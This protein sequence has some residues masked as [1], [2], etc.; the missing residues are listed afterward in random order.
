MFIIYVTLSYMFHCLDCDLHY[1][2]RLRSAYRMYALIPKENG[3]TGNEYI[4]FYCET[5]YIQL[6][7]LGTLK[8]EVNDE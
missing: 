7:W 4:L 2:I 6:A 8:L 3:R 5:E 1:G